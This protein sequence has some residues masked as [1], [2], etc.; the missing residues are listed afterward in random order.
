MASATLSAETLRGASGPVVE[1][2]QGA[3]AAL[4][5]PPGGELAEWL[6]RF[7][8]IYREA[9][10]DVDRIPWAH[11]QPCPA[12]ISWLN[13]EAP[14]L[15]RCGARAAVVGCGLGEDACALL[16]RGYQ[17]GRILILTSSVLI[18]VMG[19]GGLTRRWH[20]GV[21]ALL[22][23]LP[24]GTFL[25]AVWLIWYGWRSRRAESAEV[26]ALEYRFWDVRAKRKP[27]R[28]EAESLRAA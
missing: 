4:L 19:W 22:G 1:D 16:E 24:L 9:A 14:G 10:G 8:T 21:P 25:F 28:G 18:L 26:L 15:I 3:A 23:I 13:A 2:K 17:R 20:E 6:E 7:D 27:E 11:R 5:S 12:L